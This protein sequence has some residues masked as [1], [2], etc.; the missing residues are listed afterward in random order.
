MTTV[1]IWTAFLWHGLRTLASSTLLLAVC[2]I[3]TATPVPTVGAQAPNLTLETLDGRSVEL[4]QLVQKGPVVLVVLRGWPGY[5]CPL[6]TRQVQD[7]IAHAGEFEKK[8]V[9]QVLMIYP[10]PAG[11]L[12]AHASEFLRNKNWPVN[13]TLLL[14]PDFA[15]TSS[16]GLRWDAKQETAYPATF[17]I[18]RG[19]RIA[20]AKVSQTHGNRANAAHVIAALK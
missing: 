8:N 11:Q 20:F 16:Y 15:F 13:F 12:K 3:A 17:V 4:E 7:F 18:E 10:G 19:G 9:T 5:Q 14:D 1:H 6:C 2:T